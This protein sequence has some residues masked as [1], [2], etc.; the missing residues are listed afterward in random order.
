MTPS[1]TPLS[2]G[3]RLEPLFGRRPTITGC[4]KRDPQR[5]LFADLG[6]GWTWGGRQTRGLGNGQFLRYST[7]TRSNDT[8]Q[9]SNVD[10]S[11]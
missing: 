11:S 7:G 10:C 9:K 8:K 1:Y 2:L 5:R 4:S 6:A 3:R